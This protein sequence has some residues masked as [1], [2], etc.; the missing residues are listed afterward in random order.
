M[1]LATYDTACRH[2]A[3]GCLRVEDRAQ[4]ARQQAQR[5][6]AAYR[7]G[8]SP[9]PRRS[10]PP[11]MSDGSSSAAGSWPIRRA[12]SRMIGTTRRS[13]SGNSRQKSSTTSF[14]VEPDGLRVVAH[15]GAREDP[16]GPARKIVALEPLPELDADVGN[17]GDGFERNAAA[18]AFAAQA[19][20]K[21]IP[22]GH[23]GYL[24]HRNSRAATVTRN[25]RGLRRDRAARRR[26][27][28]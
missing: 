15:E 9:L 7:R 25:Y 16:L 20:A 17:R 4:Q 14:G 5:A 3:R 2:P 12:C 21:C 1:I 28:L 18:L 10:T 23:G 8:A 27:F 13:P 11:G 26:T 22:F 19:G 6:P 24:R